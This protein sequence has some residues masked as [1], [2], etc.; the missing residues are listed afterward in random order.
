MTSDSAVRLAYIAAAT[1]GLA[2]AFAL[3]VVLARS[4]EPV[5]PA[6]DAVAECSRADLAHYCRGARAR[7]SSFHAFG[8][9]HPIYAIDGRSSEDLV[10][11]WVSASNDAAPWIE[12][13]FPEPVSFSTVRLSHAGTAE[14]SDYTMRSYRLSCSAGAEVR[15]SLGIHSN[16]APRPLHSLQCRNVDRLRVDFDIEPGTARDLVRLYEVEVVP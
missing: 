7:V 16:E 1:Y 15:G 14:A 6:F 11:K 8:S 12:V 2:L 5:T 10:E 13:L 4:P 9:H 3:A